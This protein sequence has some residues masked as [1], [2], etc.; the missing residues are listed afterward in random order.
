MWMLGFL[1]G[2]DSI[3]ESGDRL[4]GRNQDL[5]FPPVYFLQSCVNTTE[6]F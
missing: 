2:A 5:E 4:H 3:D 6:H 1:V